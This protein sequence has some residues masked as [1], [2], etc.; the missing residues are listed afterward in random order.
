MNGGKGGEY[1]QLAEACAYFGVSK[2]TM[3]RWTKESRVEWKLS[4]TG[5][6]L[7]LLQEKA[8][9]KS[10]EKC[11]LFYSRVSSH[12]QRDD[13]NRQR[14]Y[15]IGQC[16]SDISKLKSEHYQDI[17]S[18]L[19]FKRKGLITL[20]GRVKEGNVRTVIVASKDRLARFGFELI[21][22]LCDQYGAKILV[23]DNDDNTPSEE[24]GKD[25]LSIV[26]IY[27]CK[28]NGQRRYSEKTKTKENKEKSIQ[29]CSKEDNQEGIEK[30]EIK[31][32]RK[33]KRKECYSE[34]HEAKIVSK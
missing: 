28:W 10:E 30:Q 21:E 11:I 7:I 16:P 1:V 5:R 33:G 24:L 4:P 20:L 31:C 22:W 17:A 32:S 27:C 34:M 25:L 9:T 15:I 26:Q 18:G 14:E 23:L 2:S 6:R 13:L 12:K 19:N 8:T 29:T 3:R